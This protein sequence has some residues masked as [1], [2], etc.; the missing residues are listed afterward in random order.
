MIKKNKEPQYRR[1]AEEAMAGWARSQDLV[2]EA[3]AARTEAV[4]HLR[5]VEEAYMAAGVRE[6]DLQRKTEQDT[7]YIRDLE[8]RL[9]ALSELHET[10]PGGTCA[11]CFDQA[12]CATMK[13]VTGL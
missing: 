9:L 10:K 8:Y 13:I 7:A 1:A 5:D 2:F 11:Y 12:P 4:Q 6:H 3:F